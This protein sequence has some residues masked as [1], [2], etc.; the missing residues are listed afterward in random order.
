MAVGIIAVLIGISVLAYKH[1]G[2]SSKAAGTDVALKTLVAMMNEYKL[3]NDPKRRFDNNTS[4]PTTAAP[5]PKY[6]NAQVAAPKDEVEAGQAGYSSD[7]ATMSSDA[8]LRT[9]QVLK[10]LLTIPSNKKMYADLPA[11]LRGDET[12][13]GPIILDAHRAPIIYVP[14]KGLTGVTVVG[15]AGATVVSPDNVGFWASPGNDRV[16]TTGDDNQYSW[17]K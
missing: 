5:T 17:Q 1:V 11:E 4:L 9:R 15:S 8:I 6:T 13:D 16:F 2:A 10:V 7:S 14:F 3:L 12:T